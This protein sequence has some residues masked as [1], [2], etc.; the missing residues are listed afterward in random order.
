LPEKGHKTWFVRKM[1]EENK[2]KD[3]KAER[4]SDMRYFVLFMIFDIKSVFSAYTLKIL[5][6]FFAWFNFKF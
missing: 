2:T 4:D 6:F 3:K 1:S 5:K